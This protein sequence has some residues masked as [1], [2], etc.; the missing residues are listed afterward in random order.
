[1]KAM[2]GTV[3]RA[4]AIA[5]VCGVLGVGTNLI[6]TTPVP[7]VYEPRRLWISAA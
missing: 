4:L 6:A 7:W 3:M 5:I 2:A 1:M